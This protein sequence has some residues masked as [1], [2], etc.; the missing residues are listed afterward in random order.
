MQPWQWA[1]NLIS[2]FQW[3]HESEY[4]VDITLHHS[5]GTTLLLESINILCLHRFFYL[6]G[7]SKYLL[8]IFLCRERYTLK[9]SL[10]SASQCHFNCRTNAYLA[11]P[12][13]W[14][15]FCNDKLQAKWSVFEEDFWGYTVGDTKISWS[16]FF[17][18]LMGNVQGILEE[19][20]LPFSDDFSYYLTIFT[21]QIN[22]FAVEVVV[23]VVFGCLF[24]VCEF[25]CLWFFMCVFFFL[26]ISKKLQGKHESGQNVKA[27]E[28]RMTT[29]TTNL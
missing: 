1:G 6:D 28:R 22:G 12:T 10:N 8:S 13:N 5:S 29:T 9:I 17:C 4:L 21:F 18:S 24:A 19:Q 25:L 16:Q 14:V 23:I 2:H 27:S 26:I 7:I 15:F 20:K 3:R 11:D